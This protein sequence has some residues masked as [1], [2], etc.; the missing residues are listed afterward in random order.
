M[1][2]ISH[3]LPTLAEIAQAR[4]RALLSEEVRRRKYLRDMVAIHFADCT[5]VTENYV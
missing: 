5:S 3:F 2:H 4:E 1:K